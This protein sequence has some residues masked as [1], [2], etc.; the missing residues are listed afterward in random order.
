MSP[1]VRKLIYSASLTAMVLGAVRG[2]AALPQAMHSTG[3]KA[4]TGWEQVVVD[5]LGAR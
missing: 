2:M 1:F 4:P 3:L 5:L